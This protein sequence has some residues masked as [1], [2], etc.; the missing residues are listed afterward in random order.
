MLQYGIEAFCKKCAEIGDGL[1]I[2]ILPVDVQKYK[3][4]FE[5]MV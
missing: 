3:P 5:N 4:T 2:L 1:V